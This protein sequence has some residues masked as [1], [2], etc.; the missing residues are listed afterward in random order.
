MQKKSQNVVLLVSVFYNNALQ[1]LCL[2]AYVKVT[3]ED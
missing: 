2:N 3:T 1:S